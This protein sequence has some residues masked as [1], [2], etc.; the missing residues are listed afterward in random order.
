MKPPV[1]T[2]P[3]DARAGDPPAD[4]AGA[5]PVAADDP[6]LSGPPDRERSVDR[7]TPGG[8]G[9]AQDPPGSDTV[10]RGVDPSDPDTVERGVDPSGSPV[11][12]GSPGPDDAR[13]ARAPEPPTPDAPAAKPGRRAARTF[14]PPEP[15]AGDAGGPPSAGAATGPGSPPGDPHGS[16][17]DG[18]PGIDPRIHQRRLAIARL[19]GRRRLRVVIGVIGLV[20]LVLVAWA[21]LHTGLFGARSVTITG[22]HPHTPDAAIEQ[23][24]GL[25]GHPPLVDVDPG[26]TAA[27]IEAL[28]FV[29]S[30]RVERHWPDSVTIVVTERTPAAAM[31]GPGTS[32]SLLDGSGR[33]LQV[34]AAQP[35][36]VPVLVVH[37]T[38]G[39][40]EPS[41]VGGSLPA[42]ADPA[43]AVCR[44]LPRAFAAQ[45][46][47]VTAA[48]DA[49]VVLALNS[50]ITVQ[51]G[52]DTDRQAK[53]EDVAAI[54]AHGSLPRAAVID[55]SVPQSPT[56]GS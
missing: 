20:L 40:V 1:P 11:P 50:G 23:A 15:D 3:A 19:E 54:I 53:Y 42:A 10:E 43:L 31:A 26:A 7:P 37:T 45:V 13:G 8:G 6:G 4:P 51:F 30:A 22:V 32:W 49:T 21:L 41:P 47:S 18:P 2:P 55:V 39:V 9:P 34:L 52:T 14:P 48:P 27:R 5:P 25:G 44:T 33:T 36:G 38:T 16:G 12:A 56:V 28:P 35:A 46:V 24:A 29:S 17:R